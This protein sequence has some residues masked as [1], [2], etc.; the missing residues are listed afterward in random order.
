MGLS[1]TVSEIN[2]DFSRKSPIFPP[3]VFCA[4]ADGVPLG[5]EYRC[6]G[7]KTRVMGLRDQTRS[8]TISS[9][10]WIQSTNVSDGRTPDDSKDRAYA[11]RR[12]V[13]TKQTASSVPARSWRAGTRA[14]RCVGAPDPARPNSVS[15]SPVPRRR[16]DVPRRVSDARR[17]VLS[18]SRPALLLR[19]ITTSSNDVHTL[20]GL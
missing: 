2:G 18:L 8:L 15:T 16:L 14:A 7:S 17:A 12:A 10:M 5:I 9:A 3:P 13:K 20:I 19:I 1:R 4:S 11:Q 6:R